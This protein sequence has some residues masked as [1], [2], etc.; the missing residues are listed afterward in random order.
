MVRGLIAD[1]LF[2]SSNLV[3]LSSRVVYS[4][5]REHDLGSCMCQFESGLPDQ[6]SR[7][8]FSAGCYTS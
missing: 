3:R 2:A 1:Q 4:N 8:G 5:G 7:G 6:L